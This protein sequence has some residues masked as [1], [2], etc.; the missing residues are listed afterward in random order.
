VARIGLTAND[1]IGTLGAATEDRPMPTPRL[2]LLVRGALIADSRGR[3]VRLPGP[4]SGGWMPLLDQLP[5]FPAGG[6]AAEPA[7]RAAAG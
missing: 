3:H 6:A 4:S 2:P 1:C 5:H 7:A